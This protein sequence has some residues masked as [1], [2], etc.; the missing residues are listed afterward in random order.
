MGG[1]RDHAVAGPADDIVRLEATVRGV[2][3]GV[4]FRWFV[5]REA[6]ALRLSGWVANHHDGSVRV[7]AEGRRRDLV[8][9]LGCLEEGPAGAMVE[10]V[11]PAWMPA[12][13]L[14]PGFT[15]RSL[16]HRGD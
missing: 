13:G 3:Q 1:T 14:E 2:V 7:V 16:G 10:R 15:I 12:I 9:L 11:L 6:G 4:G 8:A 5:I